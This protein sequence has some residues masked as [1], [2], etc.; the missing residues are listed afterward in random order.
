MIYR[1]L[2]LIII[3]EFGIDYEKKIV[4]IRIFNY[5]LPKPHGLCYCV[6]SE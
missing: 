4:L 2:V 1:I 3:R 5:C 6:H